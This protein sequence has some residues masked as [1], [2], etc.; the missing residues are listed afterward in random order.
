[1]LLT[2]NIMLGFNS[3][4]KIDFWW[5]LLIEFRLYKMFDLRPWIWSIVIWDNKKLQRNWYRMFRLLIWWLK[6]L[7]LS[8]QSW[9]WSKLVNRKM[10]KV[11]RPFSKIV[12]FWYLW[13]WKPWFLLGWVYLNQWS[14]ILQKNLWL[15][16]IP[17]CCHE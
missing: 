6:Y 11:L 4:S 14:Q 10:H 15:Q 5:V 16:W 9:F 8:M 2:K 13:Y 1:M 7:M 17:I 12:F 3:R